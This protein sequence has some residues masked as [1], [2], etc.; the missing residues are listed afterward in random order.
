MSCPVVPGSQ[1]ICSP[2]LKEVGP[3]G[4]STHEMSDYPRNEMC[5]AGRFLPARPGE[6]GGGL[7]YRRGV[8]PKDV[9]GE[10]E[11]GVLDWKGGRAL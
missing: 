6:T 5:V 2:A 3:A 11:R 4:R 9:P 8:R 10:A 1:S 7:A